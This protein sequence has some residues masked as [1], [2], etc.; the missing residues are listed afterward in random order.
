MENWIQDWRV[1]AGDGVNQFVHNIL[2]KRIDDIE[3]GSMQQFA[4]VFLGGALWSAACFATGGTAFAISVVG[5]SMQALPS[6]PKESSTDQIT[7][8]EERCFAHLNVVQ[9]RVHGQMRGWLVEYLEANPSATADSAEK[10]FLADW[11]ERSYWQ[12]SENGCSVKMTDITESTKKS[13]LD[14]WTRFNEQVVKIG[15]FYNAG[16]AV[17]RTG[18][19]WVATSDGTYLALV[20]TVSYHSSFTHLFIRWVDE[21][22][23]DLVLAKTQSIGELPK[24]SLS[25]L[26]NE[27]KARGGPGSGKGRKRV[28]VLPTRAQPK[29]FPQGKA[30]VIYEDE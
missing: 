9:E 16:A 25:G 4:L 27:D 8:I 18:A 14:I 10:E 3:S 23:A 17:A 7:K 13:A 29:L 11:L 2:A 19:Y 24:L 5:M 26:V 6:L 30:D 1:A 22:M 21:D 20:Q 15:D 28:I 12:E